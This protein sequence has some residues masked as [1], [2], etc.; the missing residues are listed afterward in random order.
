V[1]HFILVARPLR[2]LDDHLNLHHASIRN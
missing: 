2:N 1:V